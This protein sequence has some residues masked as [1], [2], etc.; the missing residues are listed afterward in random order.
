VRRPS[1]AGKSKNFLVSFDSSSRDQCDFM[2]SAFIG[3]LSDIKLEF[4]HVTSI[5]RKNIF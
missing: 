2:F 5:E 1:S 4:P 3:P